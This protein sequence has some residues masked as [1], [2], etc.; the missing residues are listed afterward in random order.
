MTGRTSS[1]DEVLGDALERIMERILFRRGVLPDSQ[2][3]VAVQPQR[4]NETG[5]FMTVAT[6]AIAAS[7]S[8]GT[9]RNWL[10]RGLLTKY[11]HGRI[12]RIR[13]NELLGLLSRQNAARGAARADP[14]AVAARILARKQG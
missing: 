1:L 6:A 13:R 3:L 8:V 11:G 4:S 10:R 14:D 2:P 7:V 9:V 5:E 12:V